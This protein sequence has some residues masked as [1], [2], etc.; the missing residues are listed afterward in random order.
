MHRGISHAAVPVRWS[1]PVPES[2]SLWIVLVA[3][4]VVLLTLALGIIIVIIVQQRRVFSLQ[5]RNL[6][7]AQENEARYRRLVQLSPFPLV[8]TVDDLIVFINDAT[9]RLFDAAK[10]EELVGRSLFDFVMT[11]FERRDDNRFMYLLRQGEDLYDVKGQL[12]KL[13]GAI[14]DIGVTAIPISYGEKEG[15]DRKSVV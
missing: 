10:E 15:R 8:V 14:I 3:G 1:S 12:E 2:E 13:D 5:K 7:Q 9:L 6:E 4:T 11:D